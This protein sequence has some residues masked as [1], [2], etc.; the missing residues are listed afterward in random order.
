MKTTT[1]TV[2]GGRGGRR[3]GAGANAGPAR[4]RPPVPPRA[5]LVVALVVAL[6]PAVRAAE[7][8]PYIPP[9]VH[10]ADPVPPAE[11]GP[12]NQRLWHQP[13]PSLVAPDVARGIVEDFRATYAALGQP[14][15]LFFV[16]R[17]LLAAAST[18]STVAVAAAAPAAPGVAKTGPAAA[19]PG[20]GAGDAGRRFVLADRQTA[21]DVERLFGRP[22]RLAGATLADQAVAATMLDGEEAGAV[23]RGAAGLERERAALRRHADVVV[24]IL[25]GSRTGTVPG[26][27]GGPAVAVPDIQATAIRLSDATILGQA[28]SADVLGGADGP[29]ARL[30]ARH[31]IDQVAEATALALMRDLRLGADA[32]GGG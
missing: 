10:R 15:L 12:A 29:A 7:A 19:N 20:P 4:G 13:A 22:F 2:A 25:I 17:E 26:R 31:G 11:P 18:A 14:R 24:E 32:A 6:A 28:S 27:Q 3:D 30:A 8:D 1:T 9:P 5:A 23:A 16:N 21:R